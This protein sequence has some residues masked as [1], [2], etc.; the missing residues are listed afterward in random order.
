[1]AEKDIIKHQFKKGE[2]GNPLGRPRK[3]FSSINAELRGKGIKPLSKSDLIDAYQTIFNADEGTLKEIAADKETPY[4]MKIIILELN[5]SK[6]RA[7]AMQDYRD[8]CFGMAMRS[9]DIT[10]GGK[11]INTEP[12]AINF[13]ATKKEED[14]IKDK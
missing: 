8:Y 3:S 6:T 4:A 14:G 2:S 5:N 7:K 13:V 11:P 1:M 9:T 12:V 10:S